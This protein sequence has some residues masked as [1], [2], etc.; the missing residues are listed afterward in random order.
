MKKRT[1]SYLL[2]AG[3]LSGAALGAYQ[4][5]AEAPKPPTRGT[6]TVYKGIRD[7]QIEQ[8]TSP[9]RIKA[10]ATKATS[11]SAIWQALEHG[12]KVEC[13]DCIPAVEKLLYDGNAKNREIAA[14]WLR[15]RIFG[16]FGTGEVYS[17]TV[18]ALAANPD[19]ATRARA[20]EALGE[21]LDSAGVPHVAKSLVSDAEPVVRAAAARALDRLNTPGPNGE[22]AKALGDSDEGVRLSAL[23]AAMHVHGFSDVASV[24]RLAYDD[25]PVIRRHAAGALGKMRA[26]DSVTALVGLTSPAQESDARA[27][28]SAAHALGL[29]ADPSARD[30]LMAAMSDPDSFVRDAARIALRRL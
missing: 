26:R 16:V 6:G 19:P 23:S 15:R 20:A 10:V 8:L 29:I 22:L 4:A 25:S 28:A 14:W 17:R 21:F 30:A 9:D 11:P 27:R 12:E 24:A 7:D 1:L 5:Q 3:L 2:L 18:Q 13:L